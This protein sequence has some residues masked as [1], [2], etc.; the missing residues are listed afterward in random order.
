MPSYYTMADDYWQLDFPNMPDKLAKEVEEAIAQG[1]I[2]K[3]KKQKEDLKIAIMF[4]KE[5]A[6]IAKK[7][8]N[9]VEFTNQDY[10]RTFYLTGGKLYT[11]SVLNM[12]PKMLYYTR[13]LRDCV[14][15]CEKHPVNRK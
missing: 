12:K 11:K 13:L 8:K 10:A 6:K 9:M 5:L 2:N 4:C 7:H 1:A 15:R 3:V 14:V